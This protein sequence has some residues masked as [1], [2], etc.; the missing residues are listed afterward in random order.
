MKD[1]KEMVIIL[2]DRFWNSCAKYR[3]FSNPPVQHSLCRIDDCDRD[4]RRLAKLII[5]ELPTIQDL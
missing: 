1:S 2:S 5:S 3:P 4:Y